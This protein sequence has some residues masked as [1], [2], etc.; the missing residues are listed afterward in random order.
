MAIGA[1]LAA[2]ER[3]LPVAYLEA[4]GYDMVVGRLQGN[5][6]QKLVHLWL[7]GDAYPQPR[8]KL[9]SNES[10]KNDIN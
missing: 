9:K 5:A 6:E 7:E 2:M 8:P 1:L 4:I 3:N 10:A